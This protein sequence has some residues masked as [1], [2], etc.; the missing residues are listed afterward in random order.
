MGPVSARDR[1]ILRQRA[2]LKREYSD[3]P[4]NEIILKKWRAQAAGRR[5]SPPV[6]F[7]PSNFLHEVVTP[8]L[9]CAGEQARGIEAAL[10]TQLPR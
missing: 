5:D 2:Q 4:R 6:R 1:E 3:S 9:Q 10:L 8:R 7:L